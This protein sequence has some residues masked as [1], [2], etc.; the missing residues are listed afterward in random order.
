MSVYLNVAISLGVGGWAVQAYGFW[1]G[2]VY[3]LFWEVIVGYKLASWAHGAGW[4]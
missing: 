4:W 1:W 3:L 2:V